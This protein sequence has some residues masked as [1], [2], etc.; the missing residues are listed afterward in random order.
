MISITGFWHFKEEFDYGVKVGEARLFQ[1]DNQITGH[2]V[3]NEKLT[4]GESII[5]R[6]II[7]GQVNENNIFLN[8]VGYT[9]LA[10]EINAEYLLEE[11]EGILNV[12]GQIVG[13][14]M[15]NDGIGGVFVMSRIG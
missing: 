13:S 9:I 4:N 10:G 14:V 3:F 2:L 6:T 12:Q 15:D 5:V 7:S 1:N 11:R 8:D